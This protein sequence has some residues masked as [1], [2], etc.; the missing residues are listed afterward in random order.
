MFHVLSEER[1]RQRHGSLLSNP[2]PQTDRPDGCVIARVS[3]S[4]R[5]I[6]VDDRLARLRTELRT[7]GV[8][9]EDYRQK[10]SH[11][12]SDELAYQARQERRREIM[13]EIASLSNPPKAN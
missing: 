1:M 7:I 10:K 13:Q 4:F 6:S 12:E 9:D 5:G 11:D 3:K 8:W 2:R